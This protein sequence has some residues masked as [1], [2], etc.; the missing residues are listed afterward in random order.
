[1]L[2]MVECAFTDPAREADWS[3]WYS[4][5]KLTALLSNPNF[6][7][8]QRLKAIDDV[9]APWLALHAVDPDVFQA[10]AYKRTG[11]G[12]FGEWESLITNWS[13][14]LFDGLDRAPE[15]PEGSLLVMVDRPEGPSEF[16]GVALTWLR[17]V[18]LDRT[19]T[20]RGIAVVPANAEA[21]VRA[22]VPG[23]RLYTPVSPKRTG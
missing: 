19:A 17:C 22:A 9:P 7:E 1:M 18:G 13:R 23:A 4:G 21:R 2:Y 5:P 16:P 20:H 11:G 14:N 6:Y 3:A 10:A 15:V 12:T 8:S